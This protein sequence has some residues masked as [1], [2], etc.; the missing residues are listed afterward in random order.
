PFGGELRDVE[1]ELVACLCRGGSSQHLVLRHRV[2][3]SEHQHIRKGL[4][5]V[6]R[7]KEIEIVEG[8]P[9]RA[10]I[11]VEKL[12]GGKKIE[13]RHAVGCEAIAHKLIKLLR[14]QVKRNVA[15]G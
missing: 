1:A 7:M 14:H 3:P 4:E 13:C 10:N 6:A 15:A 2:E 5:S 12:H 9:H 8:E 11:A